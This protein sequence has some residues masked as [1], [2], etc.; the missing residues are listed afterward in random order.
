MNNKGQMLALFT[1]IMPI[2]ILITIL[3]INI[4]NLQIEKNKLSSIADIAIENLVKNKKDIKTVENLIYK[5]DKNIKVKKITTNEIILEKKIN[6][7][8]N[9]NLKINTIKIHKKG[10]IKN[11]KLQINEMGN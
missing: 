4:V 1:I 11:N 10:T 9:S 8:T 5:N 6:N 7:Q 2:V 3:S